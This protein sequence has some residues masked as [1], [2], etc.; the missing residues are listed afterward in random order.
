MLGGL[1]DVSKFV[2]RLGPTAAAQRS[3]E[4]GAF[5]CST[6]HAVHARD[7]W[8][9]PPAFSLPLPPS[10][11]PSPPTQVLTGLGMVPS[12]P[13]LP[14]PPPPLH[15]AVHLDGRV[16]G[17]VRAGLAPAMVA[18]LRAIK[19]ARLAEEEDLTPGGS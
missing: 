5:R 2:C 7:N 6:I 3:E 18:H 4:H 10:L 15:L 1:V 14:L 19:A 16:V 8:P 13:L 12:Q 9:G 11:P 17:S